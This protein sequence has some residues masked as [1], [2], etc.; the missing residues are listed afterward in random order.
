M[1]AYFSQS[2][3]STLVEKS[4]KLISFLKES[5]Q[6]DEIKELLFS[7]SSELEL[8]SNMKPPRRG[9][10]DDLNE[11]LNE[12]DQLLS[13]FTFSSL[14]EHILIEL[15]SF[16]LKYINLCLSNEPQRNLQQHFDL[17]E[18]D[19]N[20]GKIEDNNLNFTLF[21]ILS[22]YGQYLFG[23]GQF[24]LAEMKYAN[25]YR[26]KDSFDKTLEIHDFAIMTFLYSYG[27]MLFGRNQFDES[28]KIL[29]ECLDAYNWQTIQE[30][31]K[32]ISNVLAS[33]KSGSLA[34]HVTSFDS[35]RRLA[36]EYHKTIRRVKEKF[37]YYHVQ[38]KIYAYA[39]YVL[40]FLYTTTNQFNKANEYFEK[41][42]NHLSNYGRFYQ[43]NNYGLILFKENPPESLGLEEIRNF[44]EEQLE[45]STDKQFEIT[46]REL[47][48]YKTYLDY[49]LNY[50]NFYTQQRNFD[51]VAKILEKLAKHT[52]R[53]LSER[54]IEMKTLQA[55]ITFRFCS[56]KYCL[57]FDKLS[58]QQIAEF[59][60][61]MKT[62]WI[63]YQNSDKEIKITL[64]EV[65][66]LNYYAT[67]EFHQKNYSTVKDISE[68][69]MESLVNQDHHIS[70]EQ[71]ALAAL[72]L[73]EKLMAEM[74]LDQSYSMNY[75]AFI[76]FRELVEKNLI[77]PQDY[78]AMLENYNIVLDRR[79]E[80]CKKLNKSE[81]LK[82]YESIKEDVEEKLKV[83]YT[84]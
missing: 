54:Y 50:A 66:S 25:A 61:Q 49:S 53:Y 59:A 75:K 46:R 34:D 11:L 35:T 47:D 27:E 51:K 39:N 1:F 64:G 62:A 22:N 36:E 41:T 77:P 56:F 80:L 4:R 60:E 71:Y 10:D 82:E 43:E 14:R 17:A 45:I 38:K 73:S 52:L 32:Q 44:L 7:L 8:L 19:F 5:N 63:S 57:N 6:I 76:T 20:A 70:K 9:G 68:E 30:E 55:I 24:R 58:N 65:K 28:E 40:A 21:Q 13:H 2:K 83:N 23:C 74:K 18:V 79:I 67:Y 81:E 16:R 33:Y 42:L 78:Q 69:I 3:W 15:A 72:V 29:L 26:L 48:P 31:D 12:L 37:V 84:S